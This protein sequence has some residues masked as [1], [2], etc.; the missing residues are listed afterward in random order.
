MEMLKQTNLFLL[1]A[2]AIIPVLIVFIWCVVDLFNKKWLRL[3]WVKLVLWI[4]VL[5]IATLLTPWIFSGIGVKFSKDKVMCE[6]MFKLALKT[7]ILPSTKSRMYL[8]LAHLY[9]YDHR[10]QDAIDMFEK[11]YKYKQNDVAVENLCSLYT[12]KGQRSYAIAACIVSEHF[13]AAAINS[14][15]KNDYEMAYT[16]IS[17]LIKTA[18]A[19]SCLAYAIR[20]QVY[21]A[22]GDME[23]FEADFAKANEICEN[24]PSIKKIYDNELYFHEHYNQLRKDYNFGDN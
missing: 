22:T 21:R 11:S 19:P 7:S 15:L 6:S 10:G 17:S 20:G 12:I 23:S 2:S 18:T 24:A 13:E 14:I 16:S 4:I 9:Y 3:I 8:Y 5:S 1:I